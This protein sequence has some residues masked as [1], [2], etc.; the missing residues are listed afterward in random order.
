VATIILSIKPEYVE[1]IFAGVKTY[2]FRRRL[3]KKDVNKIVIYCTNPIKKILG[4]V[5]VT[6]IV[7]DHPQYLWERTKEQA[8][9]SYLNYKKYFS[10]CNVAY[11]YH[12]GK[13]FKYS[14]PKKLSDFNIHKPPQSFIYLSD[15]ITMNVE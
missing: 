4:E 13:A 6:D 1:K 14:I 2:E 9:V 11:A 8:G 5:E 3:P 7:S 15:D 10:G 12:L